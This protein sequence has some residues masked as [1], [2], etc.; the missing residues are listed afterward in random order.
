MSAE[1]LFVIAVTGGF[2]GAMSG[3]SGGQRAWRSIL[4]VL[5][6]APPSFSVISLAFP[7]LG[8]GGGLLYIAIPFWLGQ[9]SGH[10]EPGAMI[11]S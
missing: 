1:I 5:L 2:V 10:L 6:S 11:L 3:M 9:G 7:S 4:N 8:L